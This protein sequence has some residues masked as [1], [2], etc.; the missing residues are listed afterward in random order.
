MDAAILVKLVHFEQDIL[1]AS[2]P[3]IISLRSKMVRRI[4]SKLGNTIET[5]TLN[6]SFLLEFVS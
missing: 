6:D 4:Q 3:V 5:T 1:L 2:R